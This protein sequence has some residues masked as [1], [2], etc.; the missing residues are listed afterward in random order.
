MRIGEQGGRQRSDER[1]GGEK[2]IPLAQWRLLGGST[3]GHVVKH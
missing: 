1:D 2:Q 3:D